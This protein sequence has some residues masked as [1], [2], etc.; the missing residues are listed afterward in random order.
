MHIL[1]TLLF[2][3][4]P[5]LLIVLIDKHF[6]MMDMKTQ[7]FDLDLNLIFHKSYVYTIICLAVI[8]PLIVAGTYLNLSAI[9]TF[10]IWY[11]IL[12]ISRGID[13]ALTI[14]VI[15][16][17]VSQIIISN[18]EVKKLLDHNYRRL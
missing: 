17:C 12:T 16:F 15:F 2:C 3:L 7:K 14:C 1:Y 8:I 18:R 4:Y 9:P 6:H 5:L 10:D 13:L 11:L